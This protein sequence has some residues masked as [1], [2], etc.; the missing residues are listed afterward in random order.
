[1]LNYEG[2]THFKKFNSHIEDAEF[3]SKKND[4]ESNWVSILE[5]PETHKP[6]IDK[7]PDVTRSTSTLYERNIRLFYSTEDLSA[8]ISEYKDC[9]KIKIFELSTF[10]TPLQALIYNST[11]INTTT[12]TTCVENPF[13]PFKKILLWIDPD[14]SLF[15]A[16]YELNAIK[17]FLERKGFNPDQIIIRYQNQ[18]TKSEFLKLYSD[19]EIDLI[20]ISSHGNTNTNDPRKSNI[21]ISVTELVELHELSSINLKRDKKRFFVLNLCQSASA[22]IRYNGMDFLGIS[23]FLTKPYQATVGHHWYTQY[24]SSAAFGSVLMFMLIQDFNW[25]EAVS[26]TQEVLSYG[27]EGIIRE[28]TT[29]FP[30]AF[31]DIELM[32]RLRSQN[33]IELDLIANWGSTSYFE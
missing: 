31:E 10:N 26:K 24:L 9:E 19:E 32:K 28:I 21:T 6:Q 17:Y 29:L 2:K 14:S 5:E 30:N 12:L 16:E 18:C 20:W 7:R 13:S 27:S 11:K 15:L 22:Y 8:L 25:A 4:I 3:V 23:Q 33:S 1:L